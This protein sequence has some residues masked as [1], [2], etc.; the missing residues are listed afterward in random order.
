MLDISIPYS[1]PAREL[2]KKKSKNKSFLFIV[3]VFF[4]LTYGKIDPFLV[5]V[6]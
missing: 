1:S 4:K 5:S 3:K 6:L 2:A